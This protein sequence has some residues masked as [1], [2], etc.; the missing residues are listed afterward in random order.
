MFLVH[1]A[2]FIDGITMTKLKYET[3]AP[4]SRSGSTSRMA[5]RNK[6]KKVVSKDELRKLM[7]KKEAEVKSS[8]R[9]KVDHPL[10]TYPFH[11]FIRCA[12]S[13]SHP[14]DQYRK[15]N[16]NNVHVKRTVPGRVSAYYSLAEIN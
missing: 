15:S 4:V 6:S 7:K 12:R 5:S 9:K 14:S 8:T 11:I 3:I 13:V 10:A 16:N 1:S 2:S